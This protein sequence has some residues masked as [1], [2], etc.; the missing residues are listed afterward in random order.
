MRHTRPM[1]RSPFFAALATV[2]GLLCCTG[3]AALIALL[4]L[5]TLRNRRQDP[6]EPPA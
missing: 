3:A 2:S 6:P 4:A 5:R 1:L